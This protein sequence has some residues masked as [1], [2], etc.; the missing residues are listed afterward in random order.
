MSTTQTLQDQHSKYAR[1]IECNQLT[2]GSPFHWISL[3]IKDF[4]SSPLI[5][6]IYGL[7]F[8]II[9]YITLQLISVEA[10]PMFI[11]PLVVAFTL[12]GPVFASALYDVAWEM[13]KGHKP[14]F[15]HSFKALLRNRIS[16]WAFAFILLLI[17]IA[18]VR[19]ASLV[20]VIFPTTSNASL[21]DMAVFLGVG[22]LIGGF[23][24][25]VVLV[26]SAFTPQMIMERRI[27]IMT[28]VFTSANAV[29]RNLVVMC[30]WGAI[31]ISCVA[32]GFATSA[33]AFVVIMPLLSFASW[34]AY[35][36]T[37][38]TKKQR[39]FE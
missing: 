29:K 26:I 20:F 9:P 12:I 5:S 13:E 30:I 36:Q 33:V 17:M 23:L 37:I 22:S 31:I 1:T 8:S 32:I 24:S 6:I 3:A 7:I 18:W 34:H 4:L 19:L 15:K 2:I 28:A 38:K 16:L 11:I 14:S 39:S 35:I 25:I 10:N 21:M 27:D